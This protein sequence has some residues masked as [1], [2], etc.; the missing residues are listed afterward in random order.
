VILAWW[1]AIA[2]VAGLAVLIWVV[3]RVRR[4]RS[5]SPAVSEIVTSMENG[6]SF[7][8]WTEELRALVVD[9]L[10]PEC[11][12]MTSGEIR[13]RSREILNGGCEDWEAELGRL[14]ELADLQKFGARRI[15][16]EEMDVLKTRLGALQ[17]SWRGAPGAAATVT[18]MGK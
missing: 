6:P 9:R 5:L 2:A 11:L 10:G 18:T 1:F 4:R 12:A 3:R 8:D 16:P 13:S 15:S 17:S 7:A 14:L